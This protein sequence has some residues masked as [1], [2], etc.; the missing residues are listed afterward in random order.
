[1]EDKPIV[2]VSRRGGSKTE[3]GVGKVASDALTKPEG[4][5]NQGIGKI[6]RQKPHLESSSLPVPASSR[7]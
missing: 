2:G 5:V 6:Q 7:R 4:M 1:M 3:G